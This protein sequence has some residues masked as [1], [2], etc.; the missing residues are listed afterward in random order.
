MAMI[1]RCGKLVDVK[2]GR[3]IEKAVLVVR[4]TRLVAAGPESEIDIPSGGDVQEVDCSEKTVL[5]GLIDTHLHFALGAGANYE[6]MFTWPDSLQLVTGILNAR[7]TLESGVT[8][9]RDCGARNRVAIDLREAA[10]RGLIISPR[11]LVCGRSITATGG[12]FYFCNAEA[13]GYQGVRKV[14]RQLLKEG[15]DFIKIM[16]S[17]GATRGTQRQRSSYTSEEIMG[18]TEEA[19]QQGKTVTAHCHATQAM[20]NAVE[21]GVD[22]IEH[23]TFIEADGDGIRHVFREDI[24]RD[25]VRKGIVA[26]NVVIAMN[27]R[28][29]LEWCFQNFRGLRRLGAKIVAGTDGL[30]L[31]K[32]AGLPVVLEM[33][34]RAG[35]EPMDA[36][37]AATTMAAEVCGLGTIGSLEAGMEADLIAVEGDLLDDMRVLRTPSLVM[38]GGVVTTRTKIMKEYRKEYNS[39]FEEYEKILKLWDE[40]AATY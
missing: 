35:A 26:D 32:T 34:V 9:A 25:M 37:R 31:Y 12:H 4:D 5:P 24:A 13:D 22:V 6:E 23:C 39:V 33:M 14:T 8:T 38:K 10:R 3:M 11:L 40:V 17:G 27:D 29:R 18:A 1:I 36:I 7:L 30:G 28:D 20:A 2:N 21:A 19:H 15:V 16:T